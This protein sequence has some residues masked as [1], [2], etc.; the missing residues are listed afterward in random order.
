[1]AYLAPRITIHAHTVGVRPEHWVA[2]SEEQGLPVQVVSSEYLGSQTLVHGQLSD[3]T[4]VDILTDTSLVSNAGQVIHM[5]FDASKVHVF[6]A[7][8]LRL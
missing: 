4:L 3:G 7:N 1:M 5:S 2:C 8:G 6:D